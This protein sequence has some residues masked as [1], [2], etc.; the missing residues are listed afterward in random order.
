[1]HPKLGGFYGAA[2][3]IQERGSVARTLRP[4]KKRLEEAMRQANDAVEIIPLL[5]TSG[6]EAG[7]S[8]HG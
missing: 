1:M 7:C 3:L 6:R 8:Q 4:M 2:Q 5:A